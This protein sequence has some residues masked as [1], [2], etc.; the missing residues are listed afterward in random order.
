MGGP[1]PIDL[2]QGE[3]ASRFRRGGRH[4]GELIEARFQEAELKR[5]DLAC[6]VACRLALGSVGREQYRLALVQVG[7]GS[8]D[9]VQMSFLYAPTSARG[10]GIIPSLHGEDMP[11]FHVDRKGLSEPGHRSRALLSLLHVSQK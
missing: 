3:P 8:D 11:R 9:L 1:Q 4:G 7:Y 5:G 10:L 2:K 6:F